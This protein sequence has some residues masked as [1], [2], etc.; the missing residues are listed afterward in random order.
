MRLI[1]KEKDYYDELISMFMVEEE[2]LRPKQKELVK[3]TAKLYVK[4][5]D[6]EEAC[7]KMAIHTALRMVQNKYLRILL[8]TTSG[9]MQY[10]A[11]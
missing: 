8:H 3:H 2:E 6:A 10:E 1:G 4:L 7:L 9:W 11:T 5:E